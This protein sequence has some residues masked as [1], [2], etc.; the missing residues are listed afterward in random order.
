MA[1]PGA[2]GASAGR[3]ERGLGFIMWVT[4]TERETSMHIA[5]MC[6]VLSNALG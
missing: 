1:G 2:L 3:E 4:D 5:T 6:T